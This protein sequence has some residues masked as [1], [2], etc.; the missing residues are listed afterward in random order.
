[1]A[2]VAKTDL[3][4]YCLTVR[5]FKRI[6]K[7]SRSRISAC[8]LKSVSRLIY[9]VVLL[10]Y[11]LCWLFS[12][13]EFAILPNCRLA[14]RYSTTWATVHVLSAWAI[15]CARYVISPWV[16]AFR[17]EL[18]ASLYGM[19]F[20][21]GVGDYSPHFVSNGVFYVCFFSYIPYILRLFPPSRGQTT[22]A[23]TV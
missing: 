9:L 1:M 15:P 13:S 20:I 10:S 6:S 17:Q 18:R 2:T 5:R 23:S 19:R 14:A 3:C 12:D 22:E 11:K 7:E 8:A 4:E 21:F 16:F